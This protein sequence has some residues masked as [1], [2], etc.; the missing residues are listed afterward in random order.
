MH[1]IFWKTDRNTEAQRNNKEAKMNFWESLLIHTYQ[2]QDVLIEEQTAS[3]LNPVYALGN[4][5]SQYQDHT[6]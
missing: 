4:V 3:D 6:T 5:T 1:Y 2:Q